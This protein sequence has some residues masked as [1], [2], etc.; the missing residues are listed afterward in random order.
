MM[1]TKIEP[2][3]RVMGRPVG[4]LEEDCGELQISDVHDPIWGNV[5]RSA[6]VPDAEEREAIANGA[7]VILQIVGHSHPVVAVFTGGWKRA[8]GP[9]S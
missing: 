6:W 9:E 3:T 1:P 8:D 7:P 5:M 2:C 4:T